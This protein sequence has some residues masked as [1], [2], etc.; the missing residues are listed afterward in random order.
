MNDT[1]SDAGAARVE[2]LLR[3]ADRCVKCGLC[4]PVCPTYGLE[5]NEA[6]SPRGRIALIQGLAEDRIGATTGTLGHLDGCL[7][8]RACEA[9]CP[10]GVPYGELMDGAY[11]ELVARGAIQPA[12][13]NDLLARWPLRLGGVATRGLVLAARAAGVLTRLKVVPLSASSS[14][15][16]WLRLTASLEGRPRAAPAYGTHE[17]HHQRRGT[18]GLHLGCVSRLVEPAVLH[19]ATRLLTAAGYDVV[20]PKGQA[21]CGAIHLHGGFATVA[22]DLAR[23]NAQAFASGTCEAVVSCA[24]GCGAVLGAA[25]RDGASAENAGATMAEV[26]DVSRFLLD[27]G[28]EGLRFRP[29]EARVLVHDPCT[30]RNV[31]GQHEAVYALLALVPGLEVTALDGNAVCCGSAGTHLLRHAATADRLAAPKVA[32]AR[33]AGAAYLATS[34]VGCALHLRLSLDG[35]RDVPE[36]L[37]PVELLARQ[38]DD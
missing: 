26:W 23:H 11:A 10:S 24:S 6:D 17:A 30:L 7:S 27:H 16:R 31:M 34:N 37:H 22:S 35:A 15:G 2:R 19:A 21:C 20:V 5:R 29:L 33:D 8:C 18:V 3:G 14:V 13:L 36:V 25:A 4:L 1:P 9:V 32:A 38:L 12:P 28:V